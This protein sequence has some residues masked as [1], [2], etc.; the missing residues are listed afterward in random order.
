M[1]NDIANHK[2]MSSLPL[3]YTVVLNWN[4]GAINQ[5]CVDSLLDCTYTNMKILFVDNGSSDGSAEDI[6]TR[7]PDIEILMNGKNLGFTGGNN[8]GIRHALEM[9][10]DMV[11][12]LNN[13][14]EVRNGF[15]EP[16]VEIIKEKS[17][18]VGPKVVDMAG[19]IWCAG[20]VISFHQ[21]LTKLRGFG[22]T[23]NGLYDKREL[24][25]FL[26]AC[27]VLISK[28]VF[29]E[30]GFL[31]EDYFCY[32]EDVDFCYRARRSGFPIIYCPDSKV[33]HN[34][35]WSTGGGYTPARKYMNALNSVRFLKKFG[36]VKSWLAFVLLDIL[37]LPLLILVRLFQGK[38]KG[39][40]AKGRGVLDGF[41]GKK[42]SDEIL[43]RYMKNK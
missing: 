39:A 12:I 7:Y 5:A 13:D 16:L 26:P 17:G 35:S 23:D 37:S 32:L 33:V 29:E 10:A 9:G 42:A 18:I 30:T 11:L 27:C 1:K 8:R 19:R 31:D 43:K 21:N 3:V 36:T 2:K 28:D 38:G 20:G 4:G 40:L 6:Q 41:M 34:F 24:V 25:D 22:C 14:V 15:L